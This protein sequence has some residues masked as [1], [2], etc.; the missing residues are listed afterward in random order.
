MRVDPLFWPGKPGKP[1][2][3]FI[4]GM[5]MDAS[6]WCSPTDARVLAGRY[7]VAVLLGRRDGELKTAFA[8]LRDLGYPVLTWSQRRPVG[9]IGIAVDELREAISRVSS[10]A[11]PGILLICHSRGG[12][13]ARKYLET[14]DSRVRLLVTLCTPHHGTTLARWASYVSPIASFLDLC[15]EKTARREARTALQRIL[16]FLGSEGLKEL[17]PGSAFYG[18]LRDGAQPGSR[19]VSVGGTEPDLVRFGGRSLAEVTARFAPRQSLPPEMVEGRGDGLVSSAS[20]VMPFAGLH[21][22]FPVNHA[23]VLFDPEVRRTILAEVQ[24]LAL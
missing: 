18:G 1:L 9:P 15:I 13:I 11:S 4:H 19:Y 23:A 8:D 10:W 24:N 3:V 5:G 20:A 21:C 17:L 7:P 2:A 22:D 16:R 6:I 12:L 14:P